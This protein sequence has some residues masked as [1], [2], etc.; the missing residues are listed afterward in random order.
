M[1]NYDFYSLNHV[2][3]KDVRQ[4]VDNLFHDNLEK[5]QDIITKKFKMALDNCQR[6]LQ[7]S[8]LFFLAV[9]TNNRTP[10]QTLQPV[11]HL[12]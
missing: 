12:V 9:S 7:S 8:A 1:E 6:L 10:L 4:C 2:E 11:K 3:F 5:N